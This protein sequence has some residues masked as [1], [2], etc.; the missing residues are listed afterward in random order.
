MTVSGSPDVAIVLRSRRGQRNDQRPRPRGRAHSSPTRPASRATA[1]AP[2]TSAEL[3]VIINLPK[4]STGTDA[5]VPLRG[6]EQGALRRARQHR[7]G[8]GPP[9]RDRA[10]TRSS[11]APAPRAP[12]PDSTSASRSRSARTNGRSSASSPPA[13]ASPNRK[14][15]PTPPCC[16]PPTTAGT[17]S[18]RS[19][20]GSPIRRRV[21]GVQGRADHQS[22]AQGEGRAPVGVLRRA[23]HHGHR[24]HHH[25]RRLHRQPDGARRAL[26][27]AQHDVQRR[28]RPHPRDRHAARARLRLRPGRLLRARRVRAARPP[29]RRCSARAPP[30]CSSTATRPRPSTGRPSARS[31]SPSPSRPRCWSRRSSGPPSSACSAASS[32]PSAPPGCRSPTGLRES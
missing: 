12:S 22:A 15:G 31:P 23:I 24:V 21:P 4:R 19:M 16:S 10:K 18:S 29:R 14:S 9:V 32:P 17:A 11:S 27:R 25:H 8:R 30:I 5:N 6:V 13:A 2:L 28:R 20:P 1:T 3:F 7:D 26:R